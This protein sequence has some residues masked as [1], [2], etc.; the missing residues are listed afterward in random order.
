M[1]NIEVIEAFGELGI[2]DYCGKAHKNG[3]YISVLNKWYCTE[4]Y[5]NF[6]ERAINHPEDRNIEE[7]NYLRT[8]KLLNIKNE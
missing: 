5:E 4:D 1:N 3:F 2:C 8:L 7:I 6:I